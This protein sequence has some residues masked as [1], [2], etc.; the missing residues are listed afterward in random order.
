LPAD[1]FPT[2]VTLGEHVWRNNRDERFTTGLDTIVRG[3][4]TAQ[5]P[6][7]GDRPRR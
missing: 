7:R 6:R 2:L 3:L 5:F 4:E 1:Q